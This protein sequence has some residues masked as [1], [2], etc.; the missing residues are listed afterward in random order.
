M[1]DT[2][3]GA[4]E[5]TLVATGL[6]KRYGA[7]NE[8]PVFTGID[9]ALSAGSLS[10]VTGPS[11]CGKSTLLHLLGLLDRPDSGSIRLGGV[12]YASLAGDAAARF[13]NRKVGFV[14]QFDHLLPELSL[15][16]N[17]AVPLRLAGLPRPAATA[18]A[19][20]LLE[21]VEL[22]DRAHRMPRELS[23]GERQRGAVARALV[24]DPDLLLADEPTGN[25]DR[26]SADRVLALFRALARRPG[27]IALIVTHDRDIAKG[28]DTIFALDRTS[29]QP[30]PTD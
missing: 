29:L 18:R 10:A 3:G 27:R 22:A 17:V 5:T 28:C 20:A 7:G 30:L 19:L 13:R 9:L 26:A 8:P 25:L 16:E 11:G 23:G 2:A 4:G 15:A 21:S 24:H 14:F 1:S 6:A 12:D